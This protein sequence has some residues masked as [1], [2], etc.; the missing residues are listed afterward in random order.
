MR[1]GTA[2]LARCLADSIQPAK[3]TDDGREVVNM[4]TM[5]KTKTTLLAMAMALL[6]ACVGVVGCSGGDAS[7]AYVGDWKLVEMQSG[8]ETMGAED[9]AAMEALGL[10]VKMTV[11]E[12]KTFSIDLFGEQQSGTW[13]AKSASDANFTID[14]STVKAT[15]KDGKL[16]LAD[17]E[18]TLVFE[19]G[20]ASASKSQ[21]AS[22]SSS[23]AAS[24]TSA[25]AA[26]SA[27]SSAASS[28]PSQAGVTPIGAILVDDDLC[29]IEVVDKKADFADDPGYTFIVR[30]HSDKAID[31]T[32]K[33]GSFSVNGK[34]VDPV[35]YETIQPGKYVE[36]FMWFSSKD[37]ASVDELT[38]VDGVISVNDSD[39]YDTLA[40]YQFMM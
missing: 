34:M 36:A 35:L 25:S 18:D 19:K 22:S 3:R 11:K 20:T 12:D 1:G 4:R 8:G 23:A 32:A 28:S 14:G 30:N 29:T 33:Y 38:E 13:E 39:T 10:S 31:V 26:S 7:K 16:T 15:L 2:A 21:A 5:A 37:V 27:N 17:G 40:E 9:L 6:L 24:S